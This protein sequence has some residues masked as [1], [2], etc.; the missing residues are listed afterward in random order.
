MKKIIKIQSLILLIGTVFALTNFSNLLFIWLNNKD[1]LNDCL[2]PEEVVNPFFTAEFYAAL[3]LILA[4]FLN[5]ILWMSCRESKE[6]VGKTAKE[7]KK[8]ELP[9][10]DISGETG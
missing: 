2:P 9:P 5:L 1:C 3:F 10:T 8:E 6:R 4:L 7:E